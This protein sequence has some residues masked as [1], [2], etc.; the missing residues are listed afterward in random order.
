MQTYED[1]KE[2]TTW[3]EL[4]KGHIWFSLTLKYIFLS[5]S[6]HALVIESVHDLSLFFFFKPHQVW[7]FFF[8]K[9]QSFLA[10][11]TLFLVSSPH[12]VTFTAIVSCLLMCPVLPL[13]C[14][15]K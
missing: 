12:A 11:E 7:V 3:I 13:I 15:S 6:V 1:M 2:T 4:P 10:Y 8:C 14:V 9:M 5:A